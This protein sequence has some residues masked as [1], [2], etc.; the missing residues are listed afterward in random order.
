MMQSD[1]L[2]GL[3]HQ[4]FFLVLVYLYFYWYLHAFLY[5][6]VLCFMVLLMHGAL[7]FMYVNGPTLQAAPGEF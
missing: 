6:M 2:I 7:L 4:C 5:G 3:R 1:M